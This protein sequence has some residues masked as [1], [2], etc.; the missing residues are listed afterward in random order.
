MISAENEIDDYDKNILS[1]IKNKGLKYIVEDL[2]QNNI[3]VLI[4]VPAIYESIYKN[5]CFQGLVVLF[6]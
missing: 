3:S 1:K 2:K 6:Y 4:C 5:I